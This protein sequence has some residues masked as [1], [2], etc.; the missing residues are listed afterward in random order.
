MGKYINWSSYNKSLVARGS[1]TFWFPED[2]DQ[3]WYARP[4]GKRGAQNIYSDVAIEALSMI[5]F[6]YGL[7]L[8]CTQRFAES[9]VGLMGLEVKVPDYT[10]ICRRF[11][12]LSITSQNKFKKQGS[13][14][15]VID[16]TGLKVYGKGE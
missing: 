6:R 13:I 15:V 8:R 4:S 12:K 7:K 2:I 14:H 9:L 10:T 3:S 1:I 5:R 16:S 11:K